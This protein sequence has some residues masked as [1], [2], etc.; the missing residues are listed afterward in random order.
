M[1]GATK[2]DP[3]DESHLRAALG[4]AARGLGQVWPNPAVGCLIVKDGHLV[5]RGWTQPGGRPHAET[6]AL[7]RAGAAARGA[8]AYVTLEPC[9]HHGRTPPCSQALIGAGI[10]RAVVALEDPDQRVAG[11]G[12]ADLGAAGVAVTTEVC[13]DE[14]AELN[15]G[16]LL[17]IRTG[18]PL[19]TVKLASSLDGRIATHTGESRW[20]TGEAARARGHLLRAT[21]DAIMI[22]VG[23]AVA[24]DPELTCRLPGLRRR[25]PVRIVVDGN[26]RLPLT[27][28]MVQSAGTAPTWLITLAGSN[29][30]RRQAFADCGVKVM[31]VPHGP[32]GMPD[33]EA[34]LHLLGE[35]GL[36]RML[37]EGGGRLVASLARAGLIDRVAWFRAATL[38]GGD[39]MPA[40]APFGLERLAEQ[41]RFQHT[42]LMA[43]GEDILESF[44]RP[45]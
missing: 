34:A 20:I 10:A 7:A 28:R 29:S 19:V 13:A 24:D 39:G 41:P 22:G 35:Q 8:T 36:T 5:G 14:A 2:I 18:R 11:R 37:V 40:V 27:S 26:M 17:R 42:G 30:E 15:A 31:T 9:A 3:I 25:S 4:L 44:A 12:L 23:T 33:L 16:F 21:H 43:L 32:G 38:I 6:E 45:G 1:A